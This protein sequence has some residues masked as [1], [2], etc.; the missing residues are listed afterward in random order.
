MINLWCRPWIV[1]PVVEEGATS[2]KRHEEKRADAFNREYIEIKRDG[3]VGS[4]PPPAGVRKA[5]NHTCH[6][7]AISLPW[8]A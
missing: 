4:A 5:E 6:G 2:E 8:Q 3:E 1:A 7:L